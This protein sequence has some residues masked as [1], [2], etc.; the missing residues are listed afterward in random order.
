M[1][2]AF[3]NPFVESRITAV[4]VDLTFEFGHHVV[5]LVSAYVPDGEVDPGETVPLTVVLRH[6]GEPD[7]RRVL[8]VRIPEAAAGRTIKLKLRPAPQVPRERGE[9]R[10]LADLVQFVLDAPPP[11]SLAVSI[12]LESRGLR[13][14]GRAVR[15]LPPSAL[16][17]LHQIHTTEPGQAFVTHEDS[18]HAVGDV[19]DGTAELEVEVRAAPR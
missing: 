5:E 10:S 12:E 18:F 7:E 15:S 11:T 4:D 9:A 1:E 17:A 19:I 14:P 16:A 8:P 6:F 2:A 3:G 13:F